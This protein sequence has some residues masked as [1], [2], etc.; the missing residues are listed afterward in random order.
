[1]NPTTPA[2]VP[3]PNQI[4]RARTHLTR[5]DLGLSEK[6]VKQ[7]MIRL[8]RDHDIHT[9]EELVANLPV[10]IDPA[11]AEKWANEVV[12]LVHSQPDA[13]PFR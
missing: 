11:L 13:H 1:M 6:G 5:S 10:E 7:S 4:Q 3:T 12:A 8:M 9:V 2:N